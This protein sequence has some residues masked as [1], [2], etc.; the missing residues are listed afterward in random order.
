[1]PHSSQI[2]ASTRL[3]R[4]RSTSSVPRKPVLRLATSD[5]RL[6]IHQ[7][8]VTAANL[9]FKRATSIHATDQRPSHLA[10][11]SSTRLMAQPRTSGEGSHLSRRNSRTGRPSM[12]HMRDT[13][14]TQNR[15][16]EISSKYTQASSSQAP[17]INDDVFPP[18]L[19]SVPYSEIEA[20]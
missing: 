1:M 18:P 3:R 19:F 16:K 12:V 10:R 17:S 9:A 11:T 4:A 5:P 15:A 14:T 6:S 13:T 20:K 7:D 8:A 2:D